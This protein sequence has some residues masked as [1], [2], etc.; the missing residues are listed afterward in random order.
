MLNNEES[1]SSAENFLFYL[2]SLVCSGAFLTL[3][4]TESASESGLL[5]F[6]ADNSLFPLYLFVFFFVAKNKI[7]LKDVVRLFAK[8]KWLLLF[9]VISFSSIVWSINPKASLKYSVIFFGS[10]LIGIYWASNFSVLEQCKKI[11]QVFLVIGIS[12][13]ACVF[14]SPEYG[15]QFDGREGYVWRGVFDNRNKLGRTM[16]LGF[17]IA[18]YS[19]VYKNLLKKLLI[20]SSFFFVAL[21]TQSKTAISISVFFIALYPIIKMFKVP[22]KVAF[23]NIS[24][25]ITILIPIS[26]W[27][28]SN[29]A[30]ILLSIGR[31]I[32][33]SGRTILWAYAISISY[34]NPVLGHGMGGFFLLIESDIISPDWASSV[35]NGFIETLISFGIIGLSVISIYFISKIRK[36]I[37]LTIRYRS[38]IFYLPLI[39]VVFTFVYNFVESMM[40]K[41]FNIIWII[42]VSFAASL[43]SGHFS[44]RVKVSR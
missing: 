10:T 26:Y 2:T 21:M 28:F 18:L 40:F 14:L 42:T 12:S 37:S 23:F 17:V 41:N 9:I 4:F 35:H 11:I 8:E 16:A 29:I 43:G 34:E 25:L 38:Q 31:D 7:L 30:S 33:L 22:K 27:A 39:V 13:V 5:F 15:L 3:G 20:S 36:A 19:R 32:T 1:K 24:F 6:L 44:E